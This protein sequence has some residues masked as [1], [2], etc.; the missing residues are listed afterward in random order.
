VGIYLLNGSAGP[1]DV[2]QITVNGQALTTPQSGLLVT[3]PPVTQTSIG[4]TNFH[5]FGCPDSCYQFFFFMWITNAGTV[6]DDLSYSTTFQAT[7]YG[8][9]G[10]LIAVVTGSSNWAGYLASGTHITAAS[11]TMSLPTMS[12]VTGPTGP[13]SSSGGEEVGYWVG[14]G[15]VNFGPVFGDQLWQAGVV[16][17]YSS[18]TS[19]LQRGLF[20][21]FT[22]TLEAYDPYINWNVT[23][24][25][26]HPIQAEV[27]ISGSFLMFLF[28]D[29]VTDRT[30][31]SGSWSV[32]TGLPTNVYPDLTTVEWVVEAPSCSTNQYWQWVSPSWSAA[33]H[34]LFSNP[35]WTDSGTGYTSYLTPIQRGW[36]SY[37]FN[38]AGCSGGVLNQIFSANGV[39]PT[40]LGFTV[41]YDGLC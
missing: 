29:S 40:F 39:V 25:T 8:V 6:A 38:E 41:D 10:W 24:N 9:G 31:W 16:Y 26:S 28:A 30:L 4:I 18:A 15:G 5:K 32:V 7:P 21:E 1:I 2:A 34:F 33:T 14:I 20:I 22:G 3:F 13:C 27:W 35:A 36:Y 19:S 23:L 17:S 11:A 12:Y 37:Y